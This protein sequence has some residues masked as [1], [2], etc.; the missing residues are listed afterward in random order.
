MDHHEPIRVN[1][2]L[3]RKAG[4]AGIPADVFIIAVG[5]DLILYLFMIQIFNLSWEPFVL[6]VVVVDGTWA[7]LTIRGVW[8]FVGLIFKPQRYVR[9]NLP[10]ISPLS[11]NG[12]S[13]NR[14]RSL[15][16]RTK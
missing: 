3:S 9:A 2:I 4:I 12:T 11:P 7:I 16:A 15:S 6:A 14:Q 8:R 1:R 13:Q 5:L 10:Y